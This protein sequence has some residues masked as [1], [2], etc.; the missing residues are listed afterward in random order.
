MTTG[1]QYTGNWYTLMSSPSHTAVVI[2]Q[3][4]T[5]GFDVRPSPGSPESDYAM[6]NFP[7][8]KWGEGHWAIAGQGNR[9]EVDDA[10]GNGCR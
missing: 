1:I 2:P 6:T 7:F 5:Y 10:A 4:V 8:W 9:W 3:Q